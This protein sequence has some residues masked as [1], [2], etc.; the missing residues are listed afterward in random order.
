MVP[1]VCDPQRL[2]QDCQLIKSRHYTLVLSAKDVLLARIDQDLDFYSALS[3]LYCII[4]TST[5][6]AVNEQ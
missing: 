1:N 3:W 6:I 2:C 5:V 4:L